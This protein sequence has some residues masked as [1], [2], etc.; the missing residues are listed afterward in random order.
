MSIH[1]KRA[2]EAPEADDGRR[3]L[4]DKFWPRGVS[5]QEAALDAWRKEV[6]PSDELREWFDHDPDRWQQFRDRYHRELAEHPEAWRPIAE[7]A[8][9][10]TVTLVYAASDR[11]HNNAVALRAFLEERIGTSAES[12]E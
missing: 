12:D 9:E 3:I 10:E 6:A 4:V 2:Y 1:L 5:K 8:R 7:A 11:D